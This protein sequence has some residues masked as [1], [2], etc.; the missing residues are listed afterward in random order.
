M[1]TRAFRSSRFWGR[2]IT[3]YDRGDQQSRANRHG[4]VPGPTSAG[5]QP[6]LVQHVLHRAASVLRSVPG[7]VRPPCSQT[8]IV[9]SGFGSL[10][11]DEYLSTLGADGMP[12]AQTDSLSNYYTLVGAFDSRDHI[13]LQEVSVSYSLPSS[14]SQSIG[15]G[16]TSLTLSGYN[17][18]W[19]D[20]CNCM[21]P[22][23]QYQPASTD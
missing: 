6:I 16:A 20:E 9:R 22:S 15:L 19:W 21:D 18:H 8:A 4:R 10:P 12:T 17:L 7:R 1:S 13:R 14:L 23:I 2:D 5:V 3:T 11:G